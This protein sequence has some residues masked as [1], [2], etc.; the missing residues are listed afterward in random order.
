[1]LIHRGRVENSNLGT[2]SIIGLYNDLSP[3]QRHVII[4]IHAHLFPFVPIGRHYNG[5]FFIKMEK[6][7]HKKNIKISYAK[8]RGQ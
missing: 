7:F 3:V 1:M 6:G 8:C 5:V 2:D 4:L